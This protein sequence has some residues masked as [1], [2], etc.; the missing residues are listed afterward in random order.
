MTA[1]SREQVPRRAANGRDIA[2][3]RTLTTGMVPIISGESGASGAMDVTADGSIA[4][5][6]HLQDAI[7]GLA[8]EL[9]PVLRS[10]SFSSRHS[11]RLK[12][13][14]MDPHS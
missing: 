10:S 6:Y 8:A 4:V 5:G 1:L 2:V 11:S 3:H 7:R 9:W 12:R 14:S 13:I